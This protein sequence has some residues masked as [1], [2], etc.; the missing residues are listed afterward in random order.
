MNST[1]ISSETRDRLVLEHRDFAEALAGEL[2]RA[3]PRHVEFEETR[4]LAFEGLVDAASRFDPR[5]GAKFKTFAWYRIRGAILDGVRRAIRQSTGSNQDGAEL[6]G[7]AAQESIDA[8]GEALV[9]EAGGAADLADA[10]GEYVVRAAVVFL[11][12]D[13]AGAGPVSSDDPAAEA[14]SAEWR[15]RIRSALESLDEPERTIVQKHYFEGLSFVECAAHLCV[16]K[17]WVSRLH[18]R[19]LER[20]RA[21]LRCSTIRPASGTRGRGGHAA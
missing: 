6:G 16:H 21:A 20:M 9:A 2:H 1:V 3:F 11:L 8:V 7:L 18:N 10:T 19:A 17:A 12:S 15:A 4:S 5:G 14:E 13:A